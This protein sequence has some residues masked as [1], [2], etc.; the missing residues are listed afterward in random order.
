MSGAQ[1]RRDAAKAGG[2]VP[3]RI[4]A[5]SLF[6]AAVVATA[7]VS[8]WPI[9]REPA[10]VVLV[11]VSAVVAVGITVVATRR[12]WSGWLVAGVVA[13]AFIVLGV[14]LAV[15]SR[16]GAP[17]EL[18]RGLGELTAG[19]AVA[20]KDL[21]TVELPV[22]SYRNLLVP[23]LVVFLVGTTALLRLSWREGRRA[24]VAIPVALA[25]V[26]FGLVFGHAD[27][28][29][30]LMLGPVTLHAPVETAL[31]VAGL[32]ACLLWLAWRAHDERVR[33]LQRAAVASGVRVARRATPADRRR[34]ALGIG[35]IAVSVVVAVAVVPFAAR[36]IDRDVL[37]SA[38]GPEIDLAAELSP[39]TQY[40]G[41]FQ[42]ERADDVLFTVELTERTPDRVRLATLDDYDGEVFRTSEGTGDGRFVRVASALEAGDGEPIELRVTIDRWDGLWM[43]TA[44]RLARVDFDGPR[45]ALLADGFYYSAEVTAGVQAAG[46]GLESGDAYRMTGVEP[47]RIPLA[48]AQAPGAPGLDTMPP[49]VRTWVEEH[50]S[51]SDGVALEAA[52]DLLRERGY[53]SHALSLG[54]DGTAVW[55]SGLSGYR[56]QPSASGHSLGRIDALFTRLLE[57]EADPRAAASGNFVAA[58]GDDEQFA[59]AVAIIARE[60]GFPSRVVVG[61]RLASDDAD[62]SVCDDGV[63]RAQHLAA[64]AEVRSAG[65][66]WIP[67]DATPQHAQSPSLEVTQQR[68]PEVVTE[69][70]P[71]SVEEIIPPEPV[72]Q[73]SVAADPSDEAAGPDLAWLWP[74]LRISG[75]VLLVLLLVLGPFLAVITAKRLRRRARRTTGTAAERV[76]GGWEEYV[77]AAIDARRDVP[78]SATRSEVAAALGTSA[79]ADLAA[80]ADEAVFAG[81]AGEPSPEAVDAYWRTV[82][83]ERHALIGANGIRRRVAATVSL[84]SIIRPLAPAKGARTLFAERGRRSGLRPLRPTP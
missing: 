82:H 81:E 65:G 21:L 61:T 20:W 24:Y 28:S 54:A 60:L 83:A 23:A 17:V 19:T 16:L 7:G 51:G 4:V 8:A 68:D 50:A 14:P 63:C 62:L 55:A 66:E 79:G 30:P 40:R 12:R 39:L 26:S 47:A 3:P 70:L 6:A 45:A 22:G 56:F 57:R 36:G 64:W 11:A 84:R 38:I 71:D 42:D 15:P 80:A 41:F 78:R 53:L 58:I 49:S 34:A 31:G 37:R 77:D 5:G 52:V 69:V 59:T 9:Y 76:A 1:R 25:M 43:P 33:A 27:V 75:M 10:F 2:R 18:V 74:V 35:M 32:L 48:Q 72:Q 67:I 44:G 46:G 29:S 73:D 13:A